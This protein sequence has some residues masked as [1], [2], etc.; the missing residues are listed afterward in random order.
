MS[1]KEIAVIVGTGSGLSASLAR[2]FA[3]AGMDV[4]LAARNTDKL[5]DLAEEIGAKTYACD[6]SEAG[7]VEAV[8]AAVASDLGTPTVAV[9]N[10]SL[11]ARG[12]IAELDP[13][14][15]KQSILTSCYG[16]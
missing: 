12:S 5:E 13:D 11:R 4:A 10:A 3:G 2:R 6:A 7:D 1:E 9:Y 8:F 14:A 15:V 16:G